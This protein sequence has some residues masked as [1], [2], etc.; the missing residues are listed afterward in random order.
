M[1]RFPMLDVEAKRELDASSS[2]LQGALYSGY[3]DA[4]DPFQANPTTENWHVLK[5]AYAM[6][7]VASL[8][9]PNEPVPL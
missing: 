7:K 4:I 1:T 5:R 8:P 9:K 3:T 6:F 2:E